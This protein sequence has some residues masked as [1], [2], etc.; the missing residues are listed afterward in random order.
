VGEPEKIKRP[1]LSIIKYFTKTK[2][3]LESKD[4][5]FTEH[6]KY[7]RTHKYYFSQSIHNPASLI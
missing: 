4:F 6:G 1:W 2:Y 7:I 3:N 5:Q